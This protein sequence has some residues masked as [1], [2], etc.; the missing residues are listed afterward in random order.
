[1]QFPMQSTRAGGSIGAN[2]WLGGAAGMGGSNK[3]C[4]RVRVFR[5]GGVQRVFFCATPS[6]ILLDHSRIFCVWL[7]TFLGEPSIG[8]CGRCGH[9]DRCN[10]DTYT[11]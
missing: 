11:R 9:A 7:L 8:P 3:V 2:G 1:M 6:E 10:T 5:T 4:Q